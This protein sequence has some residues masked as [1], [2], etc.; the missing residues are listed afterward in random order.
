[1]HRTTAAPLTALALLATAC[2]S[3]R[4]I[5]FDELT[6]LRPSQVRVTRGDRAFVVEGPQVIVGN[7]LAGFVDGEY[8][9]IPAADVTQ[10]L[11][12]VPAPGRTGA[13]IGGAA[14]GVVALAYL[15]S[16]SGASDGSC[17]PAVGDGGC[18]PGN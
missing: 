13:L 3:T 9:V 18:V 5:T 7:R 4:Q 11:M 17:N 2:H 12:R 15:V 14:I 6:A 10:V 8:Q 16:G 1:M